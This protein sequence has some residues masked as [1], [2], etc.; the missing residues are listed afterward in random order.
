MVV[1][2]SVWLNL[3]LNL[4]SKARAT[5]ASVHGT[6][7]IDDMA[8]YSVCRADCEGWRIHSTAPS[9]S[10]LINGTIQLDRMMDNPGDLGDR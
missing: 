8:R 5:S 1:T 10:F 9:L 6:G 4:F 2:G 3:L 7:L